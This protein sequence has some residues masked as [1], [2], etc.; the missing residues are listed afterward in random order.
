[1]SLS[2][3]P[4]ELLC[5][6]LREA[7]DVHPTPNAIPRVNSLWHDISLPLLHSNIKLLSY[8]RLRLFSAFEGDGVDCSHSMNTSRLLCYSPRGRNVEIK[9]PGGTPSAGVWKMIMAAL[10]RC[11]QQQHPT[12]NDDGNQEER[13]ED[14]ELGYPSC[15][16]KGVRSLKLC[17]NSHVSDP[18]LHLIVPALS[19]IKYCLFPILCSILDINGFSDLF[20]VT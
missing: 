15:S 5:H 6:I 18:D 11:Q 3:I 20:Y 1:M 13:T 9:L 19:Q 4:Y 16:Y 2:L 10:R 12:L 8:E 14:S 17:M 7:I